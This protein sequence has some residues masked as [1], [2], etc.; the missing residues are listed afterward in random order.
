MLQHC[1]NV[2]LEVF[3]L[4]GGGVALYHSAISG[5]K[6]L[7]KIPLDVALFLDAFADGLEEGGSAFRLETMVLLGRGL[8]L[9][10]F[11][12]GVCLGAV[13]LGREAT[14]FL[15]QVGIYFF[16]GFFEIIFCQFGKCSYLCSTKLVNE[17]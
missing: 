10:V 7:G 4:G 1:F 17:L 2:F 6:E 14:F 16:W 3:G 8:L 5:N 15:S 12:D 11:E 13:K 9:E